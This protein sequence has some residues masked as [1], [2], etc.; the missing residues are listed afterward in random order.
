MSRLRSKGWNFR[1]STFS[2]ISSRDH[3]F[4]RRAHQRF[5]KRELHIGELDLLS[6]LQ[7]R[8]RSAASVPAPRRAAVPA[9]AFVAAPALRRRMARTARQQF[10]RIEWL[11]QIIVRADLETDDAVHIFAARGQQQNADVRRRADP[12]QH[13][14]PIQ[15]RQH[16]VQQDQRKGFSSAR[17]SALCRRDAPRDAESESPH[18]LRQHRAELNIIVN[19]KN[20][21][22]VHVSAASSL[23]PSQRKAARKKCNKW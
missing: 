4:A 10:P 3:H 1:P 18:V 22:H 17:S 2:E 19:E 20:V 9:P 11:G 14:K 23:R 21:F 7:H 5:K 6:V 16:H 15:S 12:P 13:L 8:S